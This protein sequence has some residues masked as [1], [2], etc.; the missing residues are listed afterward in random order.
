MYYGAYAVL[1]CG[2]R[3]FTIRVRSGDEVVAVSCLKACTAAD[4]M[5][6]SLRHRNRPPGSRPGS[7]TATKRVSF[8]DPLVSSPSSSPALPRDGPGTIS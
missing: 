1:R 8:S 2:P 6:G 5:P 7:L 4:A 3:S